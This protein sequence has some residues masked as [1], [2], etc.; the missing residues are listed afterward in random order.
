[1]G[2]CGAWQTNCGRLKRITAWAFAWQ[3]A[4]HGGSR[5]IWSTGGMRWGVL[6]VV[7]QTRMVPALGRSPGDETAFM[8]HT[9]RCVGVRGASGWREH[10]DEVLLYR[11]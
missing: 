3:A 8:G 10:H 2:D 5:Q 7:P 4:S 11:C 6:R 9:T 1:M